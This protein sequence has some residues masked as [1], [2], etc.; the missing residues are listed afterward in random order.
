MKTKSQLLFFPSVSHRGKIKAPTWQE[1]ESMSTP[2]EGAS[3]RTD[4][5]K[6]KTEAFLS[7][8]EQP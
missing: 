2:G 1:K 4:P 8:Y 6:G 7:D 5:F 3:H